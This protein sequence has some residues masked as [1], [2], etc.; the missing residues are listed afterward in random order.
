LK[1]A[2]ETYLQ[3][4]VGEW[5][6]VGGVSGLRGGIAYWLFSLN[7]VLFRPTP[8]SPVIGTLEMDGWSFQNGG[9]VNPIAA[10]DAAGKNLPGQGR[11]PS[12]GGSYF[13]IGPGLRWS[14]CNKVDFG[15]ALT[16]STT[17]EQLATPWFRFEV[18]FLF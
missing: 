15:G 6:P 7:H 17:N 11:I 2:D 12:G 4:Q 9:S 13:N 8:D 1:L 14:I 3:A 5:I 18:R 10:A 16:F